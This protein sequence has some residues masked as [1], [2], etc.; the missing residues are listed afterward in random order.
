MRVFSSE[1]ATSPRRSLENS[2]I[3]DISRHR[4]LIYNGPPSV[5][6]PVIASAVK[7]RLQSNYRCLYLNS[8]ATI[9]GFRAYLSAAGTDASG[10]IASGSL[11]LSAQQ[12]QDVNGGFDCD[13]MLAKLEGAVEKALADGYAGLFGSGDMHWEFGGERNLDRLEEYETRLEELLRRS[14]ALSGICQYHRDILP[15]SA[16]QAALHTHQSVYLNETLARLNPHYC[17]PGRM[18]L[19]SRPT[20][21]TINEML[22]YLTWA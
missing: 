10:S 11:I 4:C 18:L 16:V 20:D 7:E 14:P 9:A 5:H 15:A 6:F 22:G 8:P 2:S 21:Q 1:E 17:K 19:G 12:E 13:A 3:G